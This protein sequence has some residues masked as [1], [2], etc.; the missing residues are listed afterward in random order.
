MRNDLLILQGIAEMI[1]L[2]ANLLRIW[3]D[4]EDVLGSMTRNFDSFHS[5]LQK[6][7]GTLSNKELAHEARLLIIELTDQ[8]ER[9]QYDDLTRLYVIMED[10]QAQTSASMPESTKNR[11]VES[12]RQMTDLLEVGNGVQS[13]IVGVSPLDLQDRCKAFHTA[14]RKLEAYH[15][16]S[17]RLEVDGLCSLTE[18]LHEDFRRQAADNPSGK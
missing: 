17:I 3:L 1:S 12:N 5:R 2:R 16:R 14:L 13:L 11:M 6:G 10:L 9:Y 7:A 18:R 4:L 8:W 15:E